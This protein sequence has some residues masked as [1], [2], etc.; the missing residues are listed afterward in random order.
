MLEEHKKFIEDYMAFSCKYC[1]EEKNFTNCNGVFTKCLDKALWLSQRMCEK[2]WNREE[3][4]LLWE[5]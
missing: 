5:K 4:T 2:G 3:V 1:W